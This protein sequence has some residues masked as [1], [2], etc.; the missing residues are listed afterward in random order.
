[1]KIFVVIILTLFCWMV[2]SQTPSRPV[3][4][5][6]FSGTVVQKRSDDPRPFFFRYFYDFTAAKDR[7]DGL[8]EW[9]GEIYW[10]EIIFDH[11]AATEYNVFFQGSLVTCYTNKINSTVP[12]PDFSTLN[13]VGKAV[14]DFIPVY[15]WFVDDRER[16]VTFQVYDEQAD[17]RHIK[18]LDLYDARRGFADSWT[19][20]EF[21]VAPQDPLLFVLPPIIVDTCTPIGGK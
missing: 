1:M 20:H 4:P 14:I 8:R 13:Y 10:A 7:L 16:G 18:R 12:R 6:S 11:K 3:W 21:D 17:T 15:H 9:Q 19:F 5:N 2:A